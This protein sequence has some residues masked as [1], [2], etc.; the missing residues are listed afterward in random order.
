MNAIH[1]P[2][3]TTPETNRLLS[4]FPN[5]D[6]EVVGALAANGQALARYLAQIH[7]LTIAETAETVDIFSTYG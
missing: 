1:S 6:H 7:E 4:V 2:P 5:A 3:F